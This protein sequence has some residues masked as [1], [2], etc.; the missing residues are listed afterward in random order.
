MPSELYCRYWGMPLTPLIAHNL[1]ALD[2]NTSIPYEEYLVVRKEWA[3]H[4]HVS[5]LRQ[6]LIRSLSRALVNFDIR[7]ELEVVA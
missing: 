5:A 1:R 7:G 3:C 4:P 2:Y 6:N